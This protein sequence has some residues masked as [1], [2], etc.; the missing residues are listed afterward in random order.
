MGKRTG[1]YLTDADMQRRAALSDPPHGEVYRA[2]L[3]ALEH[4]RFGP[5]V[6]RRD[7]VT[8]RFGKPVYMDVQPPGRS[9]SA[10]EQQAAIGEARRRPLAGD[11]LTVI[12]PCIHP[13][14]ARDPKN[15]SRCRCGAL[16]LPVPG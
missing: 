6:T 13:R 3:S 11:A 1:L 9:L 7:L 4:E 14:S 12:A 8:E 2:G 16:N 5:P 15:P 10:G